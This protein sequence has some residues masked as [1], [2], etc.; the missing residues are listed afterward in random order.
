MR[1]GMPASRLLRRSLPVLCDGSL[2]SPHVHTY[3]FFPRSFF[4]PPP[5][6]SQ[7]LC[8][9]FACCCVFAL[10]ASAQM[11]HLPRTFSSYFFMHS[12]DPCSVQFRSLPQAQHVR[13][14]FKHRLVGDVPAAAASMKTPHRYYSSEGPVIA[15]DMLTCQ[16]HWWTVITNINS[17]SI[18]L[19][20]PLCHVDERASSIP[21]CWIWLTRVGGSHL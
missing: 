6:L 19:N 5:T 8:V 15:A 9:L 3:L 14:F 11:F 12:A 21:G 4:P 16:K 10:C 18:P 7:S 17:G 2:H 13:C 20:I 1:S